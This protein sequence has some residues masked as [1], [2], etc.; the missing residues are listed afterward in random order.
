MGEDEV[1][2]EYLQDIEHFPSVI[3]KF[4]PYTWILADGIEIQEPSLPKLRHAAE[5]RHKTIINETQP[6]HFVP[7][8]YIRY[9]F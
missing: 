7:M 1:L 8:A 4:M 9:I 2:P 3:G 5:M 6:P